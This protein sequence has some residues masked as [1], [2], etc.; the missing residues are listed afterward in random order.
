MI[1]QCVFR[2]LQ[3]V[4]V[5]ILPRGGGMTSALIGNVCFVAKEEPIELIGAVTQVL[6]GTMFRVA[7]QQPRGVGLFRQN[8]Q[9]FHPHQRRRQGQRAN[10][11][12]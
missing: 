3:V 12:L 4:F 9:E 6:P 10:V 8:A 11:S 2:V 7:L 5:L 1:V